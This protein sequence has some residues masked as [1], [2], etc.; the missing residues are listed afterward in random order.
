M[1]TILLWRLTNVMM[2]FTW[3]KL[4][5]KTKKKSDRIWLM[6]TH[7]E[8]R[9]PRTG[10]YTPQGYIEISVEILPQKL[11]DERANGFG[12]DAP[13]IYPVLPDPKGRFNFDIFSPWKML[14]ELLGPSLSRKVICW[15]CWII[16]ILLILLF[17][18]LFGA[19]ILAA[20]VS[21]T[22]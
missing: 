11:A 5:P 19:Q 22:F 4:H 6:L 7:P 12:R 13:N 10:N 2:Q 14:K 18:Y 9:D 8:W 20:I 15:I 21:K 16:C 17:G 3:N 1:I